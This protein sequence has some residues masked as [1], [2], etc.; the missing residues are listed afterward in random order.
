[1]NGD[2][3]GTLIFWVIFFGVWGARVAEYCEQPQGR[4]V[5][6]GILLGPVGLLLLALYPRDKIKTDDPA[7]DA[8]DVLVSIRNEL[9][10]QRQQ[11]EKEIVRAKAAA[12]SNP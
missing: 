6:H 8:V 9:T 10:W 3:I 12:A 1:M 4:G 2:A 7:A 5:W 11:K